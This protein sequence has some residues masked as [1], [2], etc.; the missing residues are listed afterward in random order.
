MLSSSEAEFYAASN[1]ACD[2]T[3]MRRMLKEFGY[4]Q[5]APTPMFEDNWACIYL[6]RNSVLYHKSKHID[7]SVYHLCDLCNA[8][9]VELFKVST[10]EQVED[11]MTKSLPQPAFEK[12]RNVML[13]MPKPRTKHVMDVVDDD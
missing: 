13:G 6:L 4:E 7:V 10:T 9:V 5:D 3:F 1:G 11:V 2:V 8:G 12:F